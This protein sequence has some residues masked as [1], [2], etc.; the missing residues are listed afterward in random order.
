MVLSPVNKINEVPLKSALILGILFSLSAQAATPSLF[1]KKNGAL[2]DVEKVIAS[3]DDLQAVYGFENFCYLGNVDTVVQK[4]KSWKKKGS[5]FSGDGGGFVLRSTTVM[6]GIVTYDIALKF[7]DEVVP[8][9][10]TTITV[11]P[12]R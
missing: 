6:R 3:G 5:F 10:F 7:E 8:G 11:K 12:C 9:E 2:I 1:V 4:I